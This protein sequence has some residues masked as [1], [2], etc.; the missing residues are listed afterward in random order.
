MSSLMQIKAQNDSRLAVRAT[1]LKNTMLC[2]WECVEVKTA[3]Q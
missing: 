3:N 2:V 1:C